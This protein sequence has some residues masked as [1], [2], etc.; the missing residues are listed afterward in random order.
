MTQEERFGYSETDSFQALEMPY[1][2]KDLS[3]I[4]LLPRKV[5][6]L[7]SLERSLTLDLLNG[8][9]SSLRETKVTVF[10][11]KFTLTRQFDLGATLSAM[12]MP[13][14]FSDGADFS[15]MCTAEPLAIS[16][17][18]HKA[19]VDVNEE[20]TE[21]AAATATDMQVTSMPRITLFRADH[22]FLFLIRDKRSGAVLFIG[23][24][25]DP[26]G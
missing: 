8:A 21:A 12:G 22:P 1:K 10:L 14:A 6:G 2:G 3:M 7:E 19:F 9:L 24:V 13:V 11:P 17:V 23:R 18:L 5:D 16:K 26:R 15:G 4:V 25:T 20:G